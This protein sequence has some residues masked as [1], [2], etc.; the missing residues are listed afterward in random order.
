MAENASK[1][2]NP[3][4]L[5]TTPSSN[6]RLKRAERRERERLNFDPECDELGELVADLHAMGVLSVTDRDVAL[7]SLDRDARPEGRVATF[8][9]IRHDAATALAQR[10]I[11]WVRDLHGPDATIE[12]TALPPKGGPGRGSCAFHPGRGAGAQAW[13]A[14]RMVEG[15]NMYFGA[16]P[17]SG[18][19]DGARAATGADVT[20]YPL[21]FLD[22][23][24]QPGED[25][26]TF[27]ARM[28]EVFAKLDALKPVAMVDSGG[29][30]HVWF[31]V[32]GT[33]DRAEM[34]RRANVWNRCARGLGSDEMGDIPHIARLPFTI[35]TPSPGKRAKGRRIKLVTPVFGPDSNAPHHDFDALVAALSGPDTAPE[36][37]PTVTGRGGPGAA[38]HGDI[39]LAP[40]DDDEV[41]AD[42]VR[43]ALKLIPNNGGRFDTRDDALVLV[44]AAVRAG[45]FTNEVRAAALDWLGTWDGPVDPER[46][47]AMVASI[48][49]ADHVDGPGWKH[50]MR[51]AEE[52]S[53]D[54]P[55]HAALKREGGRSRPAA[56]GSPKGR[57]SEVDRAFEAL[58]AAGCVAWRDVQ[59]E[60]HVTLMW[61]NGVGTN[62]GLRTGA[63]AR[64]LIGWLAAKANIALARDRLAELVGRLE[65]QAFTSP[66]YDTATRIARDGDV[67]RFDFGLD[68]DM[69]GA[70]IEP[71]KWR[72]GDVSVGPTR[73]VRGDGMQPCAPPVPGIGAN[74][75]PRLLA[76]HINVPALPANLATA[77]SDDPGVRAHAALFAFFAGVFGPRA[78]AKPILA[79]TGPAGSG[80][81]TAGKYLASLVD[82]N[83]RSVTGAPRDEVHLS[84][85]VRG[86]PLRVLDN[87][88]KLDER[89]SDAI[90]RIATGDAYT[91]RRLYADGDVVAWPLHASLILSSITQDVLAREDIADRAVVL[92]LELPAIQRRESAAAEA[93]SA[94][95]P[96][97]R[98]ALFDALAGGLALLP[99]VGSAAPPCPGPRFVDAALDA[100]AIARA[101]G[102]PDWLCWNALAQSRDEA[103]AD[104]LAA[105]PL[106]L[107]IEAILNTRGGQ[108]SAPLSEW[109]ETLNATSPH[110][111]RG[112][113]PQTPRGLRSALDRLAG[114]LS[115]IG[116]A[117]KHG[118]A[119]SGA[120]KK[121]VTTIARAGTAPDVLSVDEPV[122][123]F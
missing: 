106:A 84:T 112:T 38:S 65:A 48:K 108:H 97:I 105:D 57:T 5:E 14:A 25:S 101:C 56:G 71:G 110:W 74:N 89:L 102:W 109:L 67:I 17:R 83:G 44:A 72:V 49:P 104:R 40:G 39:D 58:T 46:D 4:H 81:T 62:H 11:R 33:T 18:A 16:R 51:M 8:A 28:R 122:S 75:L 22:F 91:A 93:W 63:G 100:E 19:Y 95:E 113:G 111:V 69:S 115:R 86:A 54:A 13:L 20:D 70:I 64:T 1:L 98:G 30:R 85:L 31:R 61:P 80:K 94:A 45:N 121:R 50:L 87:L 99:T 68:R 66:Q 43:R 10:A 24:R 73:L 9:I 123:V 59:D 53:P 79:L 52:C 116:I 55:D 47:A 103:R 23:D 27:M 35:N 118:V 76:E 78:G 7:L 120:R 21:T 60:A 36:T 29:G 119:G 26:A 2:N 114:D 15:C 41:R 77:T 6:V 88:S 92:T 107:K 82:R 32:N 96:R 37:R 42:K 117:I 3:K 90:C 12:L 34:A